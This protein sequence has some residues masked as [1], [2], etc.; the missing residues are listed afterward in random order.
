MKKKKA[1]EILRQIRDDAKKK[2]TDAG[3]ESWSRVA[4]YENGVALFI[5]IICIDKNQTELVEF[6]K[7]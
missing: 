5:K 7:E 6:T 4:T 2:I 3:A 1:R